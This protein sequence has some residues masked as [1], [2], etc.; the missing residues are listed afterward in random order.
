[1][2]VRR[3]S[4][5]EQD[6]MRTSCPEP[7]ILFVN[8]DWQPCL[9]EVQLAKLQLATRGSCYNVELYVGQLPPQPCTPS[10]FHRVPLISA[11]Q[12]LHK[13]GRAGPDQA[14]AQLI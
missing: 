14:L 5:A 8:G 10:L 7:C 13:Y 1:M 11:F 4:S 9:R 6:P 3:L 2:R 12:M